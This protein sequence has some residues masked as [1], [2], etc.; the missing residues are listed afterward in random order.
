VLERLL[1]AVRG[2]ESQALVL[3]G[4]PGIGKTALLE[5]LVERAADCRVIS[6]SGVQ[7]EMELAFAAL[8]QLCAPLLAGCRPSRCHRPDA[9]RI[10]FGLDSGPAP[11]R[12]LVGLAVL[13]CSRRQ[14]LNSRCCAWSMTSNSSTAHRCGSTVAAGSGRTG[15]P[16]AG[17]S[18]PEW[19][20]A[21]NHWAV[22]SHSRATF[23]AM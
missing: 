3:V 17:T 10:T 16:L 5:Q 9:L 14:L 19:H 12:L 2:G 15:R 8:H 7:S 20:R 4:E 6:V 23:F 11:D 18:G 1:E 22:A 21:R 13:A